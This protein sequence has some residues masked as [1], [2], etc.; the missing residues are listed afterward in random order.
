VVVY[1]FFVPEYK[2]FFP[3]PIVFRCM[4]ERHT[5]RFT[6]SPILDLDATC[7]RALR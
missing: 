6:A 7:S 4:T 1:D 5:E 3:P 2:T